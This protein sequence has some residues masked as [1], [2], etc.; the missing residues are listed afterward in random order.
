VSDCHCHAGRAGDSR[1]KRGAF[2]RAKARRTR[3]Y[4]IVGRVCRESLGPI[5]EERHERC[6]SVLG[7]NRAQVKDKEA[8]IRICT[9]HSGGRKTMRSGLYVRRIK[10]GICRWPASRLVGDEKW[11]IWRAS[12]NSMAVFHYILMPTSRGRQNAERENDSVCWNH[13]RAV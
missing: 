8:L 13:T 7:F 4:N 1:Y 11:L 6:N 10:D 3:L 2:S 5:P 9:S 12:T